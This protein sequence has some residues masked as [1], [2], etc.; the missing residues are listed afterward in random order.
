[1]SDTLEAIYDGRWVGRLYY[2]SDRMRFVY[3]EEWQNEP[4]AF[5]L[6]LSMPLVGREYPD[7]VVRPFINGLLPDNN[8]VLKRWGQK[9]HVSPRNPFRMLFHIGEE[10]AGAIQ[11]V[12]SDEVDNWFGDSPP[13]GVDWLEPS[14]FVE[15]VECLVRDGSQARRMADEGQF[16]LAGAQAKTALFRDPATGNWGIP[17]GTLPTTHIIK[18]NREEFDSFEIN[19]H[20]CLRLADSLGLRAAKSWTETIGGVRA[21]IVERYDRQRIQDRNLRIHQEDCCQALGVSPDRK[22]ESEGGPS[23]KAIFDLIRESSSRPKEDAQRFL[24]AIIF[25]YLIGGTDAHSKNFSLLIAG[26]GQIRLAPLY[27]LI[28][29]LCYRHEPK[30]VKLA[31]RIGGEYLI[32]KIGVRQWE[33]AAAEW[34]LD[35][36]QVCERVTHLAGSME[37]AVSEVVRTLTAEEQAVARILPEL[38]EKVVEQSVCCLKEF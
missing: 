8:E 25:N 14:D 17:R 19:E 27:D 3:A 24:D 35:H 16:S 23:A 6:S 7:A 5:P 15:R 1:M 38:T 18:P 21:I 13:K 22:Y 10:C 26:G 31:M 37:N 33:K 28:S 36:D 12:P 29:I 30:K 4:D 32:R 9:F 11:F 34:R 2:E 20:F